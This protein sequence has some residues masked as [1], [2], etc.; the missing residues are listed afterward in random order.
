[1]IRLNDTR[2][3][4][5]YSFQSATLIPLQWRFSLFNLTC[6]LVIQFIL[7]LFDKLWN[8]VQYLELIRSVLY[9]L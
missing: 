8:F 4:I 6:Y 2:Q 3:M 7:M 5:G 9:V 1:M